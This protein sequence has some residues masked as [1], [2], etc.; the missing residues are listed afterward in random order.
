MTPFTGKRKEASETAA[1]LAAVTRA[2]TAFSYREG[3]PMGLL[4]RS[5][6]KPIAKLHVS[7]QMEASG[8]VFLMQMLG[9]PDKAWS[10]GLRQKLGVY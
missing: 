4:W 2:P 10:W 1:V 7:K 5:S 8:R 6:G 9:L 3:S